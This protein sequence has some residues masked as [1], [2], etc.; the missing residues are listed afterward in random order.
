MEASGEKPADQGP[1][2]SGQ[3][4]DEEQIRERIEEELKRVR[5]EDLMLQTISGLLNLT[6]RRIAKDDERDLAQAQLG[7]EAVRAWTELLP[8][9]AAAQV[10][11][12]LSELQ[13]LYAKQA[14]AGEGPAAEEEEPK[15]GAEEGAAPQREKPP[16]PGQGP[17]GEKPPPRL[18]TP[19]GS[20]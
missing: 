13:M 3:Q 12:A 4:P 14:E 1:E 9:E 6:V 10:R 17:A 8:D 15:E 5:V 19:P 7:I 16:G 20:N 18:W 2:E 11:Q